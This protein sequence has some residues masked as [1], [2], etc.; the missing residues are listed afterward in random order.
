MAIQLLQRAL[1]IFEDVNDRSQ[2][3]KIYNNLGLCY[4]HLGQYEKAMKFHEQS[5]S[6]H[7]EVGNRE[8]KANASVNLGTCHANLG[9]YTKALQLFEEARVIFVAVKN[10]R[11]ESNAVMHIG[12]C[13]MRLVKPEKAIQY[14]ELALAMKEKIGDHAGQAEVMHSLADGYERM[15]ILEDEFGISREKRTAKCIQLRQQALVIFKEVGD[16]AGEGRCYHDLGRTFASLGD[17][18]AAV[19]SLISGLSVLQRVEQDVGAHDDRR[20]SLFDT[21]QNIYLSLQKVLLG[22]GQPGWALGVAEQAK[23]RAL[24]HRL[25]AHNRS[26]DS[27]DIHVNDSLQNTADSLYGTV[28]GTWWAEVQGLALAEGSA[29]YIVEFSCTSSD[30]LAMWLLSGLGELIFSTTVPLSRLGGTKGRTI[31]Q[32]LAETSTSMKVRGRDATVNIDPEEVD[33]FHSNSKHDAASSERAKARCTVC[34]NILRQCVCTKKSETCEVCMLV[35]SKCE[36]SKKEELARESG[37]L[38]ELYQVLM[39]PMAKH[40]VGVQEL[41]IVPHQELFEVPW[42]ALIDADGRYL[43]ESHVIRVTP[44]LRVA[45]QAADCL[46]PS[47]EKSGHVVL[48]GNPLP[49]KL[50]SLPFAE[51]EAVRV[52]DILKRA[53]LE[54]LQNHFFRSDRK[55]QATK[56]RVKHALEGAGWAH[57]ACHGDIET[58]SL[59]LAIPTADEQEDKESSDLSMQEVQGSPGVAGVRLG[60]GATVV[61]SAC[62]TG[63]GDIKAEGVVGLARGFLLANAAATVVSLWSVSSLSF[64]I[65]LSWT[66]SCSNT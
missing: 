62:N 47:G 8:G 25:G 43:I 11:H 51:Q 46:L 56:N 42:A 57:L 65:H 48:V 4:K 13:H 32:L 31:K 21:Q 1:L 58:D 20:V 22:Q 36:C 45:Q 9:N 59:V 6:I 27:S 39:E 55:P 63:R 12:A 34:D 37:L 23:A 15:S 3:A 40:L 18:M 26:L 60:K 61:L 2:I 33:T 7:E 52:E 41:L 64:S 5:L 50:K 54:V 14:F 49:T 16:R 44:S 66:H 53:D 28:C 35:L 30:Q 29:A 38:R 10:L 17:N 19:H 24:S